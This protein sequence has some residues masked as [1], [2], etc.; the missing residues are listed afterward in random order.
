VKG[1]KVSGTVEVWRGEGEDEHPVTAEVR[2]HLFPVHPEDG[3]G[4]EVD[5]LSSSVPLTEAEVE[6]AAEVLALGRAC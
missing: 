4:Y 1:S 2:L 6:R 5:L 3:G